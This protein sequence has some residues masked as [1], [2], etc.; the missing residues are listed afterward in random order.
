MTDIFCNYVVKFAKKLALFGKVSQKFDYE[1]NGLT[2]PP[3]IICKPPPSGD[4]ER[5]DIIWGYI[6]L[7]LKKYKVNFK[8][9]FWL[10]CF[11]TCPIFI[12]GPYPF[13][14]ESQKTQNKETQKYEQNKESTDLLKI[15]NCAPFDS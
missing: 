3:V 7:K 5:S 6:L 14:V 1:I 4:F 9:Y 8:P 15:D 10:R 2:P 13:M 12:I 11:E